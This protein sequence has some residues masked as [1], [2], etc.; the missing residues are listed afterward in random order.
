MELFL[1]RKFALHAFQQ[2]FLDFRPKVLDLSSHIIQNN[3]SN[4]KFQQKFVRMSVIMWRNM[5]A[6]IERCCVKRVF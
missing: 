3:R 5:E 2:F 4:R 6:A 1:S